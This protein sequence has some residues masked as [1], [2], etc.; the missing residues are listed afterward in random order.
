MRQAIIDAIRERRKLLL[1]YYDSPGYRLVE[2]HACGVSRAGNDAVRV[3]QIEGPS[4]SGEYFGWKLMR[5]DGIT[6]IKVLAES[7]DTPR[8]GY[9]RGDKGMSHIF[10]EL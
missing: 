3:F 4:E 9:R 7:F 2:P 10:A 5:L 1:N 8:P 6:G